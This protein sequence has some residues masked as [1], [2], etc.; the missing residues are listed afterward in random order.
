VVGRFPRTFYTATVLRALKGG[1]KHGQTVVF[2]HAAGEV[3]L[4]DKILRNSE[5]RTLSAGER[6]IVFLRRHNPYGGFIL[7][8]DRAG[9]FK[10]SNGHIVPQGEGTVADE[11]R[12]LTERQ[13]DDEIE[14]IAHRAN[15]ARPLP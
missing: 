2:S 10:L 5:P 12:N 14:M 11:Q 13:F 9:A 3:E 6:Y 7:T 8:G 4:A 15:P 1:P